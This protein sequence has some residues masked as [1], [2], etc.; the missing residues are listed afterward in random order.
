MTTVQ[1]IKVRISIYPCSYLTGA[2]IIQEIEDE[3]A[4]PIFW[5]IMKSC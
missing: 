3:M 5:D 1:K 4:S 2:S